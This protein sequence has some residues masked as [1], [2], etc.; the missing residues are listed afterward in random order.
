[1]MKNSLILKIFIA[2]FVCLGLGFLSG[3]STTGAIE[4]W[5]ATINKPSFNP[6]NWI[7]GPVWSVLYIFIGI[8]F[9]RS[10]HNQ[11][12]K[13]LKLM[14]TQFIVNLIW[15]PVFFGLHQPGLAL[16]IILA[17][18]VLICL[19]ISHFWKRD[20]ISAYLLVPYLMWVSFA[21]ILNASIFY[22]N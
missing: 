17:L 20:K 3:Y 2:V 12:T 22:L 21:T 18:I 13:G 7:F 5:Y 8:V 14:A 16:M 15:S 11:D 6:P 4:G 10:W 19:C 9:A 1:M